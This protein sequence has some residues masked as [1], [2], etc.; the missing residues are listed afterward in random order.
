[1]TRARPEILF[2]LFG[3][4]TGLP[5]LG[6]RT[7]QAL[8]KAGITRPRDLLFTLPANGIDRTRRASINDVPLPGVVTV[9]VTV[10]GHRAPAGRG[11]PYRIF[12]SD[13]RIEFELVFFHP[14]ADWLQRVLPTGQRR[15]IS[16][17]VELFDGRAQMV[18]PDYILPPDE[19]GTL[20]A[21]E[22]VYPLTQGVT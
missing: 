13:S 14:R 5:G 7:A 16:G 10:G 19:A 18:H 3:E 1:M 11:R 9:E 6:P 17:R 2:P 12:V 21:F 15:V 22:P 8:E 4:I 20:P